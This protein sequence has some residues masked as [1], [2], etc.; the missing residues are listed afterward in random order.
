[1]SNIFMKSLWS[2]TIK[3]Y[4]KEI[5]LDFFCASTSY[6]TNKRSLFTEVLK[7]E[8]EEEIFSMILDND[9]TK[10]I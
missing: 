7:N 4:P 8:T 2:S 3:V 9:K 6:E 1:M 5:Y 10:P